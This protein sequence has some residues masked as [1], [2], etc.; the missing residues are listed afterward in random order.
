MNG[1]NMENYLVIGGGGIAKALAKRLAQLYS[2][3]KITVI[4]RQELTFECDNI[5]LIQIEQHSETYIASVV[6]TLTTQFDGVFCC[7]GKLHDEAI[8]PEK[9]ITHWQWQ[10]NQAIIEANAFAPFCYLVHLQKNLKDQCK[11]AVLSARVGSISDN[12][13][14][15][16]YSYRMAKAALNMLLKTASIEFKRRMPTLCL[17]AFHPGTT[18]TDLSKPFQKNVPKEKL[19]SAAFS[20][21]CLVQLAEQVT[22]EDSG[23]FYAWDGQEIEW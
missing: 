17:F 22:A 4:S 14:G 13:L 20:A 8:N 19:F 2:E 23:K 16:W 7:L 11:V 15:G 21:N 10:A 9:N 18:D 1:N 12:R 3:A 6:A 5:R